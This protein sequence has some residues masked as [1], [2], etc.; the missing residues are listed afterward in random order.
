MTSSATE[1][2][3]FSLF[4]RHKTVEKSADDNFNNTSCST[5]SICSNEWSEVRKMDQKSRTSNELEENFS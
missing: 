2:L 3:N 1:H 5:N 4:R